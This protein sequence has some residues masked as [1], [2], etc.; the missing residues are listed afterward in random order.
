MIIWGFKVKEEKASTGHFF[1][2]SCLKDAP[3]SHMRI[4][5]HFTLYWIPLFVVETLDEYVHC[6]TC[7]CDAPL[8]VLTQTREAIMLAAG[9]WSCWSCNTQNP[10][11]H[12]H[13]VSCR[14]PRAE[15]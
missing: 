2:P 7:H 13:C 6:D 14:A 1:C 12:T 8:A 15:E 10:A 3:Y 4:A 9:P 11:S 5:R